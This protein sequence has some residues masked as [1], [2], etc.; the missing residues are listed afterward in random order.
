M[1]DLAGGT[2]SKAHFRLIAL[3]VRKGVRMHALDAVSF[4]ANH[5]TL[6]GD[7]GDSRVWAS[8]FGDLVTLY[9]LAKPL[10]FRAVTEAVDSIRAESRRQ[11]ARYGGAIIE[12]ELCVIGG[13]DAIREILK[14]PQKPTGMGYLGSLT[15]PLDNGAYS[16]FVACRETG[17]TGMRDTA[18]FSRLLQSGEVKFADGAEQPANWMGDPYDASLTGSLAR[19]RADDETFDALFP[20]HP[21]SRLRRLLRQ[22]SSSFTIANRA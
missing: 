22:I 5:L 1:A 8:E 6:R 12:V 9:Y 19:N 2:Q 3:R 14:A 7:E 20:E 15:I 11:A 17:I 18:I 13:I 16:I 21:L 4:D 10:P